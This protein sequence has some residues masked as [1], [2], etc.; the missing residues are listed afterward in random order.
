MVLRATNI[1]LF[2]W[3]REMKNYSKQFAYLVQ[4]RDSGE[5][6]MWGAATYLRRK[7]GYTQDEA[8]KVFLAWIASF[9]EV[10]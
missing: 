8:N 10:K 9:K 4:L 7:F 1:I 5:T 6:N 3:R 2:M